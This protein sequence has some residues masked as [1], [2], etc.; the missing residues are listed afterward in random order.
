MAHGQGLV[1]ERARDPGRLPGAGGG[2]ARTMDIAV[3]MVMMVLVLMM[4]P[5][6][7]DRF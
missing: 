7:P 5:Y 3:F 6:P 1:R 2:G 4:G